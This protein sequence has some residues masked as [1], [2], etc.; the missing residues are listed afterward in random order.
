MT[1]LGFMK[2]SLWNVVKRCKGNIPDL[3]SFLVLSFV[4]T[5]RRVA[6]VTLCAEGSKMRQEFLE[7]PA[8]AFVPPGGLVRSLLIV[9]KLVQCGLRL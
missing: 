5:L 2:H 3:L 6:L 1:G 4:C 7:K 8:V 9:E